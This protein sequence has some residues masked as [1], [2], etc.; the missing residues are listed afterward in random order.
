[1]LQVEWFDSCVRVCLTSCAV[2]WCGVCVCMRLPLSQ[3]MSCQ[4]ERH[5]TEQRWLPPRLAEAAPQRP[6]H[7]AE[8]PSWLCC[9]PARH[10]QTHVKTRKYRIGHTTYFALEARVCSERQE[11]SHHIVM[12]FDNGPHQ[13][14]FLIGLFS[15]IVSIKIS[16]MSYQQDTAVL[17]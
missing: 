15:E 8:P 2:Y 10:M 12:S 5:V 4:H 1:M 6:C 17:A 13:A 3:R 11:R 9:R 7:T 16:I 14:R